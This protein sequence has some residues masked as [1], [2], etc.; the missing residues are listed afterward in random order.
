MYDITFAQ[1]QDGK[2]SYKLPID[3]L[4]LTI[5][6]LS[7]VSGKDLYTEGVDYDI[8]DNSYLL[9]EDGVVPKSGKYIANQALYLLPSIT[10]IYFP[11]FGEPDIPEKVVSGK[12]YL[13]YTKGYNDLSFFDRQVAYAKH[14][15]LFVQS[16]SNS[17]MR[18]P[19][20]KNLY[21]AYCVL[22]GMPFS[23]EAGQVSDIIGQEITVSGETLI[24]YVLPTPLTSAVEVG[25]SVDKFHILA[26]GISLHDYIKSPDVINEITVNSPE[27]A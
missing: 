23:Y 7:G 5:P 25:Q 11:A 14:L 20:F 9:F 1:R 6:L 16:V 22:F 21:R 3:K 27:E 24:T 2:Y 8:V 13:P 4:Y 10:K 26:S 19:S 12:Y 15:K 17:L 18:G